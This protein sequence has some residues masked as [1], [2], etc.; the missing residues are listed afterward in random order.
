[1][2]NPILKRA[3]VVGAGMAGLAAAKAVAAHFETVIVFDRDALPDGT[4]QAWHTHGLLAGGHR[5]LERLLPG[6][7]RDF[8][9]A[10]A[11]RIR[12]SPSASSVRSACTDANFGTT[13]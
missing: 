8:I 7:E 11:V 10:G 13:I 1:M 5:T 12:Q 3:V 9:A 2:S 4:P 6:I